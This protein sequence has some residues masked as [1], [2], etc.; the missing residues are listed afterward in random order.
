MAVLAAR[1]VLGVA[2]GRV[3]GRS[4]ASGSK[5]ADLVTH[6]FPE[7][8]HRVVA[9]ALRYDEPVRLRPGAAADG[10]QVTATIDGVTAPRR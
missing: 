2:P 6:V 4:R 1:W 9:V 7:T 8:G 10:V 5:R 3:G